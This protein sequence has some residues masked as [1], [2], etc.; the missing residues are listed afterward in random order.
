MVDELLAKT[1]QIRSGAYTLAGMSKQRFISRLTWMKALLRFDLGNLYNKHTFRNICTTLESLKLDRADGT[2]R[3]QPYCIFIT[4]YPGCGKSTFALQVA[5]AC[6]KKRYGAAYSSDVVTLNETDEYQSEYRTSHKVVIFD[7]IGAEKISSPQAKNPW[8]KIIDFVNNIRKTSLNPNVEMK[9]VVYIEPDL[10]ILTSNLKEEMLST[11]WLYAPQAI[12][13]RLSKLIKL[14]SG[15]Q[16]GQAMVPTFTN[17][18]ESQ[19]FSRRLYNRFTGIELQTQEKIIQDLVEDFTKHLDEQEDFVRW[20]NSN[21]D[22]EPEDTNTLQSFYTDVVRPILPKKID[23]EK[24]LERQLPWYHRLVRKM[25]VVDH[26]IATI[27]IAQIQQDLYDKTI[28]DEGELPY[29]PQSGMRSEPN[30]E[31]YPQILVPDAGDF[32][33]KVSS[34]DVSGATDTS[35]PQT[36][37]VNTLILREFMRYDAWLSSFAMDLQRPF[38]PNVRHVILTAP[39]ELDLVGYELENNR[40]PVDLI[41]RYKT[42]FLTTYYIVEVKSQ[43]TLKKALKQARRYVKNLS[44]DRAKTL[45]RVY[46]CPVA[47]TNTGVRGNQLPKGRPRLAI[48]ESHKLVVQWRNNYLDRCGAV[49][50]GT[51]EH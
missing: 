17:S 3:K 23:M 37:V 45:P 32:Q 2:I 10:V 25:C 42:E 6:L 50:S 26:T 28:L 35:S 33:S 51:A 41:F 29:E 44:A 40:S 4:G 27:P 9:G 19:A 24:Y 34:L 46:F 30:L 36:D 16:Q 43:D 20:T 39:S 18:L 15:F 21:F 38:D 7:D 12:Y 1:T 49:G 8:R 22:A 14:D 11:C 5:T 13:R 48:V 47:F 31:F